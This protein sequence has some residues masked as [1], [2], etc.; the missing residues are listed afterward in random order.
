MGFLQAV[1]QVVLGVN[2]L[3]LVL[4]GFSFIFIEPGT[5]PYVMAVL[6]LIP[7]VLS[8]VASVAIIYTGWDP[9]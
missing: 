4:L 7:V 2:F 5:G 8:L 6:T 1:S 3:F 9:F